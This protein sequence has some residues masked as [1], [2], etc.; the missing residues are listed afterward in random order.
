MH[1]IDYENNHVY[2]WKKTTFF[3]DKSRKQQKKLVRFSDHDNES[4]NDTMAT[5]ALDL[6]LEQFS[7][8]TAP[9]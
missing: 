9:D 3:P 5:T 4:A 2:T 7:T 1:G 6:S 8:P